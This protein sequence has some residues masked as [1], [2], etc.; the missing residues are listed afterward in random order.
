M[1]KVPRTVWALGFVSLCMDLSSELVHG[2]LPVFMTAVLG[3][4]A[5]IGL[6]ILLASDIRAV[7]WVA[8][9]PAVVSVVVLVLFV[10]EPPATPAGHAN[11]LSRAALGELTL[12]YWFV[13]A[14]GAVFTLARFSEAF[15]VLR[16]RDLGM[17]LA[18]VPVVLVAMNL[19]YT[20]LAYPAGLAV[21]KGYRNHLL[22]WGLSALIAADLV[23]ASFASLAA[24]FAGVLLWGA[25]MGLT[26][27]L[28]SA[29]VADTA[30]APLRGTAF[31]VFHLVSGVALL[32]ASVLAGWLWS[33]RG[34]A[35][36]F[37]AGA[38]FTATALAGLVA[39][40]HVN[41]TRTRP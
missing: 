34:A 31:G 6:M 4:L 29:L 23:I 3:P 19:A 22:G 20:A 39:Y 41:R 18:M 11:P 30:P 33:E 13:V 7:L 8:V 1:N 15:L 17:A 5:A 27:G 14:L 38:A 16:A 40:I 2:L 36:T 24:L 26:Q 9:V 35:G 32:A 25:H 10:R 28:L 21:D 12:R 37:Y